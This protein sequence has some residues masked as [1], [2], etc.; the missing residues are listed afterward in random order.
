MTKFKVGDYVEVTHPSEG[1]EEYKGTKGCVVHIKGQKKYKL[2]DEPMYFFESELTL[3]AANSQQLGKFQEIA[4]NIGSFT[5]DK[6][7]QYGSSV[8]ATYDIMKALMERYSNEDDT[9]T[10]PKSL[11][12]HLLLQVR[13]MDKINRVF[14]NPSGKGDSESPYKDLT[15]YSLI[16]VD[17]VERLKQDNQ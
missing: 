17:M 2:E 7:K 8:D 12:P 4:N 10:I 9:Y 11:L 14:N 16:G 3:I 15:G 13:M 1:V 5:D 6:N